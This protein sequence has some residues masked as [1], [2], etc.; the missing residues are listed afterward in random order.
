[1]RR[2]IPEPNHHR[3][4]RHA[5]CQRREARTISAACA[6]LVLVLSAFLPVVAT[7]A[8]AA[9]VSAYDDLLPEPRDEVEAEL[10]ATLSRYE[11]VARLDPATGTIAGQ[12]GVE[13]VNTTGAPLTEVYFR[14]FPNAYY[15]GEGAL[16]VAD[17]TADGDP[18][19]AE[20]SVEETVLRVPLAEPLADG[21]RVEIAF[22]FVATVPA[23][24]TGSYG[25][26]SRA[27]AAGTWILADWY[28]ILAGWEPDRGWR[29]DAPTS[30]GDPTFGSAA[31]YEV[32]LTAP[33]GW[34]VVTSG[35]AVDDL[36]VENGWR[37]LRYVAGP[38][39]DFTLVADDDYVTLKAESAGTT[40]RSFATPGREEAARAALETAVAGLEIYGRLFGAYPYEELDLVEAPLV[41]TLGVAWAG[42]VFLDGPGMY[43]ATFY[44]NLELFAFVVA[45]EIGHQWWSAIVGVNSNDHTF[46]AEGLTNY[47]AVVW[48]EEAL[49][50]EAGRRILEGS[51]A[52]PYLALLNS[53][54]DMVADV[55]IEEGLTGRGPI[56]YGKS[57]LGFHAIRRQIGDEAFFA[58]L[59]AFAD[60]FAF[61][62]AEPVDLL[63]A[64]EAA[65]GQEL[66]E[67]WR[68]W[69]QAAETTPADVEALLAA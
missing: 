59:A 67:L 23:D 3:P 64:F 15:Y 65:S 11:I 44:E 20:L 57:A 45:H 42:V 8:R 26:F 36:G 22:S 7:L 29:L 43:G 61:A 51:V 50:A 31:L 27:T 38:V 30:F 19:A 48:V 17:A 41:S 18:V 28:P 53:A 37:T 63:A 40:V 58:G 13:F 1:M 55:P 69:F 56:W 47:V 66:D 32:D 35:Q 2:P 6:V 9:E 49:G 12:E 16:T 62:I 14:L 5:R 10:D 52:A 4:S 25:I 39:R 60:R 46:L 34:R 24:T 33:E 21:E 54:G 68:D